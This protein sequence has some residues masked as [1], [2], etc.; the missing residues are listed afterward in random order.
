M[1]AAGARD[2]CAAALFCKMLSGMALQGLF[3]STVLLAEYEATLEP[4]L[5]SIVLY[6]AL[7]E[8]AA[9]RGAQFV[10][11]VYCDRVRA[12]LAELA[13]Q[14]FYEYAAQGGTLS[15]RWSQSLKVCAP[16]GIGGGAADRGVVLLHRRGTNEDLYLG[17]V[18]DPSVLPRGFAAPREVVFCCGGAIR[19]EWFPS[20]WPSSFPR[21]L[22]SNARARSWRSYVHVWACKI[23]YSVRAVGA[24][25]GA[26]QPR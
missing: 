26:C 18:S 21:G 15:S 1:R 25:N 24:R 22:M 5:M 23:L 10:V 20:P 12:A 2:I 13:P 9:H 17:D 11:V 4:V 14:V 7:K 19:R 16:I 6:V 8:L 3:S